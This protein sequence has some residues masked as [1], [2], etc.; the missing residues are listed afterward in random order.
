VSLTSSLFRF[1]RLSA[2]LR[3]LRSP[4]TAGKRVVRIGVGRT[5]ARTGIFRWPK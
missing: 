2:T 4:K 5:L 1:A 3:S